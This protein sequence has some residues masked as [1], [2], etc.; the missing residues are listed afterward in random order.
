MHIP[1]LLGGLHG[2]EDDVF[3]FG[4][5]GCL[6]HAVA[7][8]IECGNEQDALHVLG[9]KH[10]VEGLHV[11]VRHGYDVLN[12]IT[13]E[14]KFGEVVLKGL[15][16]EVLLKDAGSHVGHLLFTLAMEKNYLNFIFA[17][18]NASVKGNAIE[19]V[20]KVGLGNATAE[21]ALEVY[22]EVKAYAI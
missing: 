12:G 9:F 4:L 17:C 5:E 1:A 20:A 11:E 14:G 22:D 10:S 21:H 6:T 19:P 13:G 2:E 18:T 8:F 16:V 15:S 7:V 3:A